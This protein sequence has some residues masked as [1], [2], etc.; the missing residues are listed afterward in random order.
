MEKNTSLSEYR[1]KHQE[2]NPKRF[3]E[4]ERE[5]KLEGEI[6]RLL[7]EIRKENKITQKELAEI[8]GVSQP[9]IG[10]FES[11]KSNNPTIGFLNNLFGSLGYEL[12]LE[13]KK[14]V[15]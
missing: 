4:I 13:V 2:K 10:R 3:D 1:K 6:H 9:V 15:K 12:T 5:V 14:I 7:A 11:G 8:S